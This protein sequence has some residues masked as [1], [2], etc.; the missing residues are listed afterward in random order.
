MLSRRRRPSL[1]KS[2]AYIL[3]PH[4]HGANSSL[5][6]LEKLN[7]RHPIHQHRGPPLVLTSPHL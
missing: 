3:Y 2:H 5:L 7:R 1:L 6:K 4:L